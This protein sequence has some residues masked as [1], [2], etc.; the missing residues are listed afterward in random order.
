MLVKWDPIQHILIASKTHLLK[1][2]H[3]ERVITGQ[4]GPVPPLTN[5]GKIL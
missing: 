2:C 1:I 4:P 3:Q 5:L